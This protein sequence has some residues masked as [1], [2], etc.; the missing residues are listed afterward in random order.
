MDL[1]LAMKKGRP[2][3]Q[4]FGKLQA[5]PIAKAMSEL[6]DDQLK[7]T[8]WI[9]LYNAAFL[10]LRKEVGLVKPGIFTEKAIVI[11]GIPLSLDDVEHG[12]LRRFRWKWSAGYLPVL[13][14]S[15]PVRQLAV[16]RLDPRIH[17]A[18][19]CGAVSCPPIAV[20][21]P[22]MIEAQLDLAASSFIASETNIDPEKRLVALNR[23]FLW[24]HGD[25][26]GHQ[27][28]RKM[29]GHYLDL[30]LRGYRISFREYDWTED[31]ERFN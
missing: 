31:L 18:L 19:N 22:S 12:I 14:P 25:F 30:D 20:Y 13:L 23:I 2:A 10:Y 3:G 27:G 7:K 21:E 11:G 4:L 1:L 6:A 9:N 24:Y 8:F 16:Q 28:I 17:F 5:Y 26:S 15:R 29:V